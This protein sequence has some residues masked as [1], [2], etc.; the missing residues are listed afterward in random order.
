MAVAWTIQGEAGKDWDETIETFADR[1]IE[2]A[3]FEFKNLSTDTFQ[4]QVSSFNIAAE[5]LPELE[6]KIVVYRD[7]Q[8]C[9]TGHVTN[10]VVRIQPSSQVCIIEVSGPW[11]WMTKT[12]FTS[13]QTIG[14]SATQQE[15][16]SILLG[17]STGQNLST[18][19]STVINRCVDLGVP[20]AKTTATYNPSTVAT[21]G[22]FS[23]MTL[24]QS[25]CDVT[26][27]EVIRNCPDAMVFFDYSPE[28]P[29]M[30]IVRRKSGLASG[31]AT[32][33]T[34]DANTAPITALDVNPVLGLKVD[35]VEIKSLT[36]QVNGRTIYATP[37][38]FP[39]SG[40]FDRD[41]TQVIA[42]SGKELDTFLPNNLYDT[43]T[44]TTTTSLATA[45]LKV[46]SAGQE[47][48][49]KYS[50][51]PITTAGFQA[52][53]RN[54]TA[55]G[56]TLTYYNVPQARISQSGTIYLFGANGNETP[57]D[58]AIKQMGLI[59]ANIT[60]AIV[61][62]LNYGLSQARYD[63]FITL[64]SS[65]DV[66][67]G[68]SNLV[69][70][71]GLTE[72]IKVYVRAGTALTSPVYRDPDFVYVA[73][74]AGMAQFLKEAQDY[75]PYEGTITL[76]E[77]DVG[78]TQYFGRTINITNSM[79]EYASMRALVSGVSVDVKSGQ[80]VISIGQ[81]VRHNFDNIMDRI[82]KTSQDNIIILNS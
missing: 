41:K 16:L 23:Q 57:P 52:T 58:W 27:S 28:I 40:T 80:T 71:R 2:D 29:A 75:L 39:T 35:Q 61:G 66:L 64:F 55:T 44:F 24:N 63:A 72:P 4:F 49:S 68:S 19:L 70:W 37:Q 59:E 34:F 31:S 30:R 11:W 48:A 10:K 60:G 54:N 9:F 51:N 32:D 43:V 69:S 12:P 15:R 5:T 22:S 18:S 20:M 7:G 62:Y 1:L 13:S 65:S 77:Q 46:S 26:F 82:R 45:I 47:Y 81:P 21:M 56:F 76:E 6:Q 79:A 73:P 8:R 3:T 53:I 78:G 67:Y 36:R 14:T 38:K 74:P 17:P 50:D 42:M 25:T 33:I